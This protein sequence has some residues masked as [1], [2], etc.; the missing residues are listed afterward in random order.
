MATLGVE[1]KQRI[2]SSVSG[3]RKQASWHNHKS[4]HMQPLSDCLR[5]QMRQCPF[6]QQTSASKATP[7]IEEPRVPPHLL[8]RGAIPVV[9][10]VH[11][12]H[13]AGPAL[14]LGHKL[15]TG[16]RREREVG[17]R[18]EDTD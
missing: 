18:D 13:G 5:E 17:S 9:V 3:R 12:S 2:G 1:N 8:Q 4:C 7:P 16:D 11:A 10:P 6:P 14:G 15:H